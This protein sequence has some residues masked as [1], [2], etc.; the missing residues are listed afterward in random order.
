M[1]RQ[2]LAQD[3]PRMVAPRE[4]SW[5]ITGTLLWSVVLFG[6]MAIC[7]VV[8]V[9]ALARW[10]GITLS[11]DAVAIKGA[12]NPVWLASL[13][14]IVTLPP[15]CLVLWIASRTIGRRFSDY[16][17]LRAPTP[18]HAAIGL[19]AT[20][21]LVALSDMVEY[22]FGLPSGAKAMGDG[23]AAAP[24]FAM[25][26]L[27]A[28]SLIV[29]TPIGEEIVFRGFIYPGLAASPLRPVGA[30]VVSAILFTAMHVQYGMVGLAEVL[31]MGLLFGT[32]RAL[33][34]STLLTIGMHAIVNSVAFVEA[35]SISQIINRSH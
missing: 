7:G 23:I 14:S 8:A 17:A 15:L 6:V 20:L 31:V 24:S 4:A 32:M 10:R 19:A 33:S 29:T 35:V 2:T 22:V 5:T 12:L 34:G 28:I 21:A 11:D 13:T 1:I 30:V 16:L 25:L 27:A 18:R 26:S 3:I 9:I